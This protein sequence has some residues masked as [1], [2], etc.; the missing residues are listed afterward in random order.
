[1]MREKY[2]GPGVQGYEYL[3]KAVLYGLAAIYLLNCMS[4]LRLH[5]D[6]LRY[7]AIKD[8]VELGC[9]PD[10][11]AAKDYLPWGYTGLLLVLSK[12][13]I[14][15][16]AVL[17]FINCLYL[18]GGLYFVRKLC[19]FRVSSFIPALL[20][21][22]NWTVI[23]FVTHPLSEMQYLFFSMASL[24]YFHCYTE[25]KRV[26]YLLAAFAAAA[27]AFVTRSVGL[28]LAAALAAGLV[29]AYRLQL[30]ELIRRNRLLFAVVIAIFAGVVIFSKQLGLNHYTGVFGKQFREGLTFGKMLKWHF[31]EWAELCL[32]MPGI[33]LE[34][35]FGAG[36]VGILF[37]VAGI[38]FFSGF[39]YLLFFRKND[40]PV[41][42]KLYLFC[43]SVLMFDWPFYDPRFWVPVVPLIAV[44]FCTISFRGPGW[45][46]VLAGGW[47]TVYVLPGTLWVLY[48][49]YTSVSAQ[50]MAKTQ[51]SGAFRNEYE[52]IWYGKPL[53]DTARH[54]DS[55]ALE[56]IRRYDR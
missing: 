30:M 24:Y 15:K 43:Y 48:F 2:A 49:T 14:L 51:A 40:I 32:N 44:V 7:F 1:M 53:S 38:F 33:K 34:A 50:T 29:W 21:L 23:K 16:S 55:A 37:F 45:R 52:T 11:V 41:I 10:S 26:V 6:M 19:G 13:G 3:V 35:Y 56:V 22:L 18:F 36:P 20:V 5:T 39:V 27:L 17:V 42:A 4:H 28:A 9:P 31:T 54:I 8:C 46:K 25:R 12:I 47:L